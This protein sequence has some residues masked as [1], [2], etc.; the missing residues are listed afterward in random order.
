MR[1]DGVNDRRGFLVLFGKVYADLDMAALDLVVDRLANVMQQACAARLNRVETQLARHHA[2]D[3]RDLDRVLKNIL[4][5]ARAVAQ[6][7]EDLDQLGVDAVDAGLEG[8]AFALALD[9][10]LDLAA[11]LFDHFLNACRMDASVH[12]QLFERQTR[13][14]AAYRVE[15]GQ[16]NR[17]RRVV[18]DEVYA[19]Q[20]LERA[21]IAALA[22]DDAAL[23]LIVGQRNDRDGRLGNVVSRAALDGGGDDLAGSLLALVLEPLVDLAD[24]DGSVMLRFGLDRVDEHFA[25]FVA[26]HARDLFELFY[27]LVL[28]ALE[29]VLLLLYGFQMTAQLFVLAVE[30]VALLVERFLALN[31]TALELL[32]LVAALLQLAVCLDALTMDLV[33]R[34]EHGLALFGLTGLDRLVDDAGRLGFSIADRFFGNALAIKKTNDNAHSETYDTGDDRY[35][36]FGHVKVCPPV[37]KI[38]QLLPVAATF[39]TNLYKIRPLPR[40]IGGT[41]SASLY[42]SAKMPTTADRCC[43]ENA[44]GVFGHRN[45]RAPQYQPMRTRCNNAP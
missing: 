8:S 13:D 22:A 2:G 27:L 30:G 32:R 34:L 29:L 4:A 18:D 5:V 14:L 40:G 35:D 12:D 31:E 1:L 17:L 7:A 37:D 11:G 15:R 41:G 9:D 39:L 45:E 3:V 24:L 44:C 16:G 42:C 10:L 38:G 28:D 23:H 20:R 33:L 6:A 19:G 43:R 36:D 21:D 25:C 26:R